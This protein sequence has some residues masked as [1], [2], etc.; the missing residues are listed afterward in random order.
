MKKQIGLSKKSDFFLRKADRASIPGVKTAQTGKI[1]GG[2]LK[3]N[4]VALYYQLIA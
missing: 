4:S 2:V 3:K 1:G